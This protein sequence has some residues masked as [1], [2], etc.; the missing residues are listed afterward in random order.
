MGYTGHMHSSAHEQLQAQEQRLPLPARIPT[1][2]PTAASMRRL[3]Y[4]WERLDRQ[5]RKRALACVLTRAQVE[6]LI[7]ARIALAAV[8]ARVRAQATV[9]VR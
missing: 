1:H 6:D 5:R 3:I 9:V 2:I 7:R 8:A 4:M